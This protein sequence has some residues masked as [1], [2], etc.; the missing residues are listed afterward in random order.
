MNW[1]VLYKEKLIS[2]EGVA[3]KIKSNS[4]IVTGHAAG[5]PKK[6]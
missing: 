5:E 2:A 4:R 3:K 1:K 6:S